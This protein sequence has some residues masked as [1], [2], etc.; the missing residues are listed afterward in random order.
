MTGSKLHNDARWP[1]AHTWLAGGCNPGAEG[2]LRV[3]GVPLV[4]G[5][6]TPGRCDLAPR[7]M[8]TALER[9]S[10]CDVMRGRDVR[11]LR[12]ED[13]GDVPVADLTVEEALWQIVAA[14][15][16]S[17]QDAEALVLLGG[18]NAVTLPGCM[19]MLMDLK[20]SALL[21]LDAHLDLR[22]LEGGLRNGNPVRALLREGLPGE[23]VVQV[24]IQS[25]ANSPEYL[26]VALDAGIT[27]VPVEQ[28]ADEGIE[29]VMLR[30][31]A[32]LSERADAIYFD[33]DLDVMDRSYA[34]AT[35]GSRPGGI[36]PLDARRA[37][38]VC[39]L[40]RKVKVMD[41]VEMDPTQDVHD[42]TALAAA[43]CLLSFSSGVLGRAR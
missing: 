33:L 11:D 18:D 9:L 22:D 5:S 20:R 17:L 10:T 41:L 43:A 6:I 1:R 3:M 35:P 7:A 40:H 21:T 4:K 8:R 39:G 37:A 29:A 26:G 38:Y 42:V 28:V 24:G 2:L 13:L 30:A 15:H 16:G 36:T 31:L 19:G 27:V 12:A 14:V 34:P 32:E 25:F 23:N